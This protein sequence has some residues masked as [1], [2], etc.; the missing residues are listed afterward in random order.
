MNYL[1]ENEQIKIYWFVQFDGDFL[2]IHKSKRVISLTHGDLIAEVYRD[3]NY[4]RFPGTSKRI[5]VSTIR[6]NA[7]RCNILLS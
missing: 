1:N 6:R 4:F 7:I 3:K 2:F 5:A